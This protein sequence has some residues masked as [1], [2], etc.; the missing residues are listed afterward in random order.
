L[1][2]LLQSA[3][4]RHGPWLRLLRGRRNLS[5]PILRLAFAMV[6][7]HRARRSGSRFGA[8]PA[9]AVVGLRNPG[10][11]SN[12]VHWSRACAALAR[13]CLCVLPFIPSPAAAD[14]DSLENAIKATYL[15]K[16]A[17][18]ITWPASSL[19]SDQFVL[20]VVGDGPFGAVLE[21]ATAGQTAQNR[22]IAIRR[23]KTISGDP[24]CQL[25]YVAGS[26]AQSVAQILALVR[27]APVLTVTDGQG[28]DHPAGIINFILQDG[29]VRFDIASNAATINHLSVSSKLLAVAAKIRGEKGS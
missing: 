21:H 10:R 9:G 17:A 29:Y 20:C 4:P 6:A 2:G 3:L 14:G 18:F 1:D 27:S 25:M 8:P 22:P 28:E 24:G 19:P 26:Q 12:V 16:F 5:S 7:R 15:Y 13:A 23:F 11:N